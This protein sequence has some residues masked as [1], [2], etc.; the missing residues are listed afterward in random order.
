MRSVVVVVLAWNGERWLRPCLSAL[1]A[2]AY[3]GR[4]ATLVVDNGSTDDSAALVADEFP[5]AALV[6]AGRNLGFAGGN[7]L[8]LRALRDGAAPAPADFRPDVAVLL[9]QDTEV[10]PGWL[11]ALMD[12]FERHPEA[13]VA[14]C[15]IFGP[16]GRVQH[17]GGRLRW[18]LAEGDHHGAGQPDGP[19][20]D[21][22]RP[23][24]W[25]TGAALAIRMDM[26]AEL[27]LLDE[28]FSPAYYEDVD[29]CFRA[30]AAG[31]Q[32]VYAP[33]A[34][35]RHH[36]NSSL[37]AQSAGHQ[38]AYHHGRLR[39][40]LRHGPLGPALPAFVAAERAAIRRWS[41]ADSLA[42]KAAYRDALADL[43]AILAPRGAL[44]ELPAV[45]S[46]LRALH[47]AAV[48][49]EHARRGEGIGDKGRGGGGGTGMGVEG[50]AG[51]APAGSPAEALV[52]AAT[53]SQDQERDMSNQQS[54]A[55]E[56]APVDVAAI[57]R[58]IRKNIAER[59]EREDDRELD[60]ALA[61]ANER[62]SKIH[63]PLRLPPA[64][65]LP[66][67]AWEL[68]RMRLHHEVRSY[69]DPMIFRQTEFNSAVVRALNSLARRGPAANPEVE[70]LR[71]ELIQLREEVRRLREQ[72]EQ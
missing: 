12:A 5:E 2:Q 31:R 40:L 49:E 10:D 43:P 9:N 53:L 30:R 72:V 17:A 35:L 20:F 27:A 4:H 64:G 52:P 48:A 32:V 66:G 14:G 19:D 8:A 71:D 63:E 33:Q 23:V 6:R 57:M 22:E 69:L 61:E 62:W 65:S 51:G 38:R 34:R 16:D 26:P 21:E 24:E 7:N 56:E 59:R 68:L 37:G 28:G 47:A 1:R 25:V 50:P 45:A 70:A 36:E 54:A 15:K 60:R 13:G 3:P 39:F 55:P 67:R 42:R 46:T 41:L 29:L 58:Q 44:A 11:A 18:P